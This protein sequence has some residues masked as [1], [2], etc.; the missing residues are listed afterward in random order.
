MVAAI[1]TDSAA[2]ST[3][4]CCAVLNAVSSITCFTFVNVTVFLR[5]EGS[6]R[7]LNPLPTLYMPYCVLLTAVFLPTL[8]ARLVVC[9]RRGGAGQRADYFFRGVTAPFVADAGTNGSSR[10][11]ILYLRSTSLT[12]IKSAFRKY[13]Q[14]FLGCTYCVCCICHYQWTFF[15]TPQRCN[16]Y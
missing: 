11:D 6:A 14:I 4:K 1:A 15:E 5:H 12:A 16:N 3:P 9:G 7:K 2:F 8:S 13:F 10:S